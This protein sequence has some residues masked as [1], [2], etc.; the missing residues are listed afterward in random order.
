[1]MVCKGSGVLLGVANFVLTGCVSLTEKRNIFVVFLRFYSILDPV[2]IGSDVFWECNL[3]LHLALSWI[4]FLCR[5]QCVS[6]RIWCVTET[7]LE[8]CTDC[9]AD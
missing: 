6:K 5:I 7:E 4:R 1:M 9:F 2:F 3:M 8:V